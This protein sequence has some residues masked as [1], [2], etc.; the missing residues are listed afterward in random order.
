MNSGMESIVEEPGL[1]TVQQAGTVPALVSRCHGP[2]S[3]GSVTAELAVVLPAVMVL[4]ALLLLGFST[5]LLQLRLEEGA[6]AGARALARGESPGQV[7]EA[8][9]RVSGEGVTVTVDRTEGYGTVTVSGRAGGVLSGLVPWTQS[10][11]ATA[12]DDSAVPS[13]VQR[14][15]RSNPADGSAALF[16]DG[17][18]VHKSS[19]WRWARSPEC[20]LRD[21]RCEAL[22]MDGG[23]VDHGRQ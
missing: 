22:A 14:K 5:S 11:Q 1:G 4:L 19:L 12:K 9:S 18:T 13:P 23:V 3:R 21:G 7:V 2:R 16:M 6:R 17:S 20:P 10:A 15:K 8:A